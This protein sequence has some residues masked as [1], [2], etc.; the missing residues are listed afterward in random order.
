MEYGFVTWWEEHLVGDKTHLW[1]PKIEYGKIM[2]LVQISDP[3]LDT[4][5][6][7]LDPRLGP[8]RDKKT[9]ILPHS[10]NFGYLTL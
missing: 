8:Q 5:N 7:E 4:K 3:K 10:I 6:H 9:R 1:G 2:D